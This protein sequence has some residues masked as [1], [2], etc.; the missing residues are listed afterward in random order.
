M[1]DG[2]KNTTNFPKD[3]FRSGVK[4]PDT[5]VVLATGPNGL[6]YYKDIGNR[7][8]IAVNKAQYLAKEL[9][10]ITDVWM[11]STPYY[12]RYEQDWWLQALEY[13]KKIGT[14]V[15]FNWQLANTI[16]MDNVDF[17]YYQAPPPFVDAIE[18]GVLLGGGTISSLALQAHLQLADDPKTILIGA[19]MNGCTYADGTYSRHKPDENWG[20]LE[21]FQRVVDYSRQHAEVVSWSETALDLEIKAPE[22]RQP[23]RYVLPY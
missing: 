16:G 20:E 19:D 9:G 17:T 1:T 11:V 2:H 13:A 4:W 7:F 3:I 18:P 22:K 14:Q 10:L 6:P 15:V 23:K 8:T 21:I 12:A 5:V